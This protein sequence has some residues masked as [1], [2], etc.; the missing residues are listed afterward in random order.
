MTSRNLAVYLRERSPAAQY[1]SRYYPNTPAYML[2][3][4]SDT[5]HKHF[6]GLCSPRLMEQ[7]FH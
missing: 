1:I 2:E 4:T 3:V 7:S 5:A 6:R